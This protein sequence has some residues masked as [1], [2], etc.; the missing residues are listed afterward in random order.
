[1]IDSPVS[2][3][4]EMLSMPALSTSVSTS[5]HESNFFMERTARV[6]RST[7]LEMSENSDQ[8]ISALQTMMTMITPIVRFK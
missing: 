3:R 2:I 6:Y 7:F 1:M 8:E 5:H 4:V